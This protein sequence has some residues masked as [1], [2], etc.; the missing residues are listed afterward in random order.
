MDCAIGLGYGTVLSPFFLILNFDPFISIPSILISQSIAGLIA[1]YFHHRNGNVRF[2]PKKDKNNN[3][4]IT[5]VIITF[6]VISTILSVFLA[7]NLETIWIK[8]Y[9]TILVAA[10]GS[11]LLLNRKFLFS[12]KKVV[13]FSV[14]TGINKSFSAGG[15]VITTGLIISGKN[16]KNSIAITTVSEAPICI[17]GFVMYALLNGISNVL[18]P[19]LMTIGAVLAAPLGTF[20]T[21]KLNET[22]ARKI[23]GILTISLAILAFLRS[24]IWI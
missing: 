24:F 5:L 4:R 3:I 19:I 21:M 12:W 2:E 8:I 13:F 20:T 14:L 11:I 16:A 10:M 23:I 7:V 17:C 9:I 15:N 22:K 18:F 6:G 1:G